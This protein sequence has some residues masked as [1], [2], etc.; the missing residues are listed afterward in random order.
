MATETPTIK[1]ENRVNIVSFMKF[2]KKIS[3][4][5]ST[6]QI[7][8]TTKVEEEG[9]EVTKYLNIKVT[10]KIDLTEFSD[11]RVQM[12]G[13]FTGNM[14]EGKTSLQMQ[15]TSIKELPTGK[16][17][18]AITFTTYTKF[19]KE[20]QGE[21]NWTSAQASLRF[22]AGKKDAENIQYVNLELSGSKAQLNLKDGETI[23]VKGFLKA[24]WVPANDTRPGYTKPVLVA[25]EVIERSGEGTAPVA[26]PAAEAPSDAA[27]PAPT[28]APAVT[29][30]EDEIP[31]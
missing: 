7:T 16:G 6:G 2:A 23:T 4:T 31:F 1:R 27:A 17:N 13:F 5:F 11:K 21:A 26:T 8:L 28:D 24:G 30:D 19:V 10:S 20:G 18:S 12:Q 9:K 15:I 3:D 22:N 25:L 29:I 14:Y